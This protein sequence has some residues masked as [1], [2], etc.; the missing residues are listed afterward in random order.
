MNNFFK[1]FL[2]ALL[3][4]VV[5]NILAGVFLVLVFAGTLA[6]LSS[7]SVV[8]VPSNSILKIELSDPVYDNPPVNPLSTIDF[9]TMRV[10]SRMALADI[11]GAIERAAY[12]PGIKG[13]YLAPT[14]MNMGLATLEEIRRAV[15]KFRQS[16][17]FVVSYADH[18]TQGSYYFATAADDI[19]L[20]PEGGLS[21]QGLASNTIFFKGALEK[22]GIEPEIIRHGEFKSAVE[23]FILDKMSN[24]SR[25]QME[26]FVNG[27]WKNILKDIS[28]ARGI[29]ASL[30]YEYATDLSVTDAAGAAAAGMVDGLKYTGEVEQRLRDLVGSG[31][32]VFI[33][34]GD[35][36]GRPAKG[37]R[38][39]KNKIAVVYA[40]GDIVDGK[41]AET[42]I[43]GETTAARLAKVREDKS[44]KAVVFRVNSGG[45]SALASEV[46][47]REMELLRA[48]K[49]VVVSMGD[50][51][52]SGGYYIACPADA[53]LASPYT[54]TGSIGVFGLMFNAEQGL[55]EKLGITVDVV[56][57]NPS[58]DLGRA[59]FGFAGVRPMTQ[60]EKNVMQNEVERVYTT[61]VRHVADGRN[62]TFDE[63]DRIGGGRVWAGVNALE[64][65]LIDGFGGLTEAVALA[66]DRAGVSGDY[67]VV[68]PSRQQDSFSQI[69]NMLYDARSGRLLQGEM[70]ALVEDYQDF[71]DMLARPGVQAAMPY[72][73]RLEL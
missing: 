12:D 72:I 21:W 55:K 25:Y 61:F 69:F 53:I 62:L 51:A 44:V 14:S 15:I 19:Y 18:Y 17:K 63:V 57:T 59:I 23:P 28:E 8:S 39:S 52:A 49:P 36:M 68:Y 13:I 3:A 60:Y 71:V 5:A 46:I 45:G 70:G 58:A 56:K 43:G 37:G 35:Y 20:N 66:A 73:I 10:Q 16:G 42:Q 27:M 9:M 11:L 24:D 6:A 38:A 7:G 4:I 50:Y 47:W 2:A 29:D 64:V 65:G 31:E 40:E 67:R 32:P 41:G 1:T 30:L 33:S 34:L 22:L 48:E 54:L 26:L